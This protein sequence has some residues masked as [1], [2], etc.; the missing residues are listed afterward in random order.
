MSRGRSPGAD[1][2]HAGFFEQ[3]H[4]GTLFLDEVGDAP[5]LVQAMLLRVL[6]TREIQ[7]VGAETTRVVD[8]RVIAAS[9]AEL[10]SDPEFRPQLYHRLAG[11]TLGV[12]PLR[13]RIDD[14]GVLLVAFL[15][16]ELTAAGAAERLTSMDPTAPPWLPSAALRAFAR[17]RWPGNVRELA[18]VARHLAIEGRHGPIAIEDAL[19]PLGLQ[20]TAEPIAAAP[21]E[22]TDDVLVAALASQ[23]WKIGATATALGISRTTLYALMERCPQLRKA[24]E[25]THDEIVASR[26]QAAGDLDQMAEALRVSR[27]GL[28][29][30]MRELG[31]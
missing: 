1:R 30:R 31:L 17:H 29:L 14:L 3:A 24:R 18:N 6:E 23:R 19:A 12:P 16:R 9:D 4:G 10:R 28:Q 8:V 20:A 27:R 25:L 7:P 26:D 5:E 13:A 11:Y 15:A 2:A 22:I 21:R